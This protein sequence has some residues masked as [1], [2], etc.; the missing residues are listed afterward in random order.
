MKK[1]KID[2]KY[3]HNQPEYERIYKVLYTLD[4]EVSW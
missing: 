2:K 4:N 1:D 3:D